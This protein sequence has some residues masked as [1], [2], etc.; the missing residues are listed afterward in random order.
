MMPGSAQLE[1]TAEA[2]VT[3]GDE[4]WFRS[5]RR[6]FPE[7]PKPELELMV[8]VIDTWRFVRANA[9]AKVRSP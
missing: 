4:M 2:S 8:T 7:A 1:A 9:S 3:C 6:A 5:M